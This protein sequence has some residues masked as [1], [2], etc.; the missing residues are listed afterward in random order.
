MRAWIKMTR[1]KNQAARRHVSMLPVLDI[2]K[3]RMRSSMIV[4]KL[5]SLVPIF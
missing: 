1:E 2:P 3:S 4:R 5:E